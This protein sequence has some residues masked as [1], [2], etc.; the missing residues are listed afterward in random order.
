MADLSRS[1]STLSC[2]KAGATFIDLMIAIVIIGIIAASGMPVITSI[3]YEAKAKAEVGTADA[4]RSGIRFYFIQSQSMNRVPAYPETLDSASN[5]SVSPSNQFFTNVLSMVS[6]RDWSKNG[7]AYTGP[8]GAV[9]AYDPATGKF[10][11]GIGLLNTWGLD[12]GSGNTVGLG[13]YTGTITGNAQWTTGKVG[14]ALHFDGQG[15]YVGVPDTP[16]LNLTTAGTLE[17]W[18]NVDSIPP[19]AGIIHKGDYPDFSDE[20]YSLQFWTGNR[21]GLFVNPTGSSYYGDC[22]YVLSKT[23]I[24]PSQWY[25]VV[26]TWDPSGMK[27]Y[28]N[29]ALDNSTASTAIAL[30]SSGHLNIGSQVQHDYNPTWMNLP[31]HGTI[32][33]VQIYD[34][35]ISADEVAAYY[36]S[37]K[38]G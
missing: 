34:R 19:F 29:G 36:N 27:I 32:D 1:G 4:V 28:V 11:A 17:A 30:K 31:F 3:Q 9:Y 38:G 13:P 26:A 14:G 24:N 35:A 8:T 18:I 15:S 20:A 12:E 23:V 6:V 7:L 21:L 16:A 10:E 33:E 25:H 37:T 5:G 22:A 2:N